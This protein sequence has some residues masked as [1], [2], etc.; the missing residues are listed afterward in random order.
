MLVNLRVISL[1]KTVNIFLNL[2][3]LNSNC[4]LI[5]ICHIILV[6]VQVAFKQSMVEI[7]RCKL[8][9]VFFIGFSPVGFNDILEE[10]LHLINIVNEDLK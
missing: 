6:Q 9:Q 1:D 3:L 7:K 8:F 5:Y 2:L 4:L 10:L